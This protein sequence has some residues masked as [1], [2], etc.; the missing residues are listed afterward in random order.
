MQKLLLVVGLL[1]IVYSCPSV[2]ASGSLFVTSAN[3]GR[4]F[5]YD[6]TTGAFIKD[7][8]PT[9]YYPYGLA[10]GP[11]GNLYTANSSLFD[12]GTTPPVDRFD[13][14]TGKLL[15]SFGG[16]RLTRGM[17]IGPDGLIYVS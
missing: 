13:P 15:A 2:A 14:S 17:T 9:G 3:A 7:F 5:Q 12:D 10:Y 11:D 1:T 4:V 6:Q 16:V 8:Q